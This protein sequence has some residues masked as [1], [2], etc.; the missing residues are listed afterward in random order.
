MFVSVLLQITCVLLALSVAIDWTERAG[1]ES[2]RVASSSVHWC[3]A[4]A[5]LLC[6]VVIRAG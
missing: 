4:P 1:R 3:K 6:G 5:T 2:A